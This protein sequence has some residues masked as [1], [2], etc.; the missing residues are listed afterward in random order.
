[1]RGVGIGAAL[2]AEIERR[3]RAAERVALSLSTTTSNP[4]R[5]LYERAGFRVV[6]TLDDPAYRV[7]TGIAGRVLM[8]KRLG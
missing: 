6:E 7:L 8:V 2:L 4:A 3:A 1:M 5:R